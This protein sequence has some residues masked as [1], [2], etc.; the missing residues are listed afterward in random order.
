MSLGGVTAVFFQ[1]PATA[2]EPD[3]SARNK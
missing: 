1:P 2:R 3:K